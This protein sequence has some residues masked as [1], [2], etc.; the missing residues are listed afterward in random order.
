[1]AT[2]KI[3]FNSK[4]FK[5]TRDVISAYIAAK[6]DLAQ[7]LDTFRKSVSEYAKIIAK[8]KAQ[9]TA[10]SLGLKEVDG[11]KILRSMAK[12]RESLATNTETY[13]EY[14]KP[15]NAMVEKTAD[16]ITKAVT[17]FNNKDSALYK[18]Y[19]A[20]VEDTTDDNYNAYADAMASRLQ[21]LGLKDAT[22]EN[23]AHLMPNVD[24]ELRGSRAV[25][26]GD[27]QGAA[28]PNAFANALLRKI[29][30]QNKSEF[31]TEKFAEYVRKCAEEAKKTK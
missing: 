6:E 20:Y 12:I 22:A 25:K 3:Q 15:Y 4:D 5:A 16:A 10:L 24:V 21:E 2:K 17:L 28:N 29:Y 7:E 1:M 23:V 8:D 13:N 18:A 26:K 19:V 14:L 11:V 27:I 9:L 30:V 31:K